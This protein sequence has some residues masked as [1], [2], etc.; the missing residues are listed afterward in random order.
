VTLL[1][2]AIRD[3]SAELAAAGVP[4]PEPDA[5][6]LACHLL[7]T[8]RGDLWRHL[9]E[10]A[11]SGYHELV[12][13]RAQRVPLQH[14]TGVAYFRHLTLQVGPGVFVP[15]PETEVLVD[16]ALDRLA[17]VQP[18]DRRPVLVDLCS[19]SGAIA[20]SV[21]HE[22]PGTRVHAVEV[23]RQA[24]SWL[25][26]NVGDLDVA[27]HEGDIT[28]PAALLDELGLP[29]ATV[30]VVTANPPYIP[31]G[32]VPRDPEVRE[33]DPDIALYSGADGLDH[34]RLVEQVA[35]RL[36]R[37][38][39]WVVVEHADVQGRSAPAVFA[40]PGAGSRWTGVSDHLDLAGRPR[41]VTAQRAGG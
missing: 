12:R 35:A 41:V 7:D 33:H 17:R 26:R 15:R 21:A 18:P 10:P 11:P 23:D 32:S 25:R 37:P 39:G 24:L 6:E 2:D 36:L 5:R 27:V 29:A 14:L 13:R 19:G 16:L 3:A 30:D 40:G 38:G 34:V 31:S 4:S 1:R 22:A 20:A 9:D 28:A 8:T